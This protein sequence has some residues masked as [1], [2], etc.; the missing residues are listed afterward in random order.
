M[1]LDVYQK[2]MTVQTIEKQSLNELHLRS[3]YLNRRI[4]DSNA[5]SDF[6]TDENYRNFEKLMNEKRILNLN[7]VDKT[8]I[9]IAD[10]Q[11]K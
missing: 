8:K 5:L 3:S 7:D 4:T 10:V 2:I 11:R 1:N 9:N 6:F